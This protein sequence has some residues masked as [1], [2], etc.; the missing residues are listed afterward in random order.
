[1]RLRW[2]AGTPL[3]RRFVAGEASYC[4]KAASCSRRFNMV[5]LPSVTTRPRRSRTRGADGRRDWDG[6]DEKPTTALTLGLIAIMTGA[7]WAQ[8]L[9]ADL[10]VIGAPVPGGMNYQPAVTEVAHDMHWLSNM[11]HGIMLV[12]VLFVT[13]LLAAVVIK[14]N[15]QANP[16]PGHLYAQHHDRDRLD[17]GSGADPDRHRLVL[18]A[19][20]VQAAGDPD[21]GPDDQGDG[22]PVVL[23]L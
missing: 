22:Q 8:P 19:D 10:P 17:A 4:R 5:H 6:R 7:A 14:F 12:I 11:V 2:V 18:A 21:P 3:G 16:V 1:M 13:A 20:P 15:R 23:E 9:P